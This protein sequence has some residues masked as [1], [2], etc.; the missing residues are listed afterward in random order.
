MA[1]D[2]DRWPYAGEHGD[3]SGFP[4]AHVGLRR[5]VRAQT[6]HSTG[7]WIIGVDSRCPRRGRREARGADVDPDD[8]VVNIA[9][10]GASAYAPEHTFPAYDLG[11]RL[12]ADYIEQDLQ[13]TA[14]GRLVA[15]HD[16]T[17]D[18]TAEGPSQN[19][20]G[21]VRT[22]TLA[23]IK[24]CDV[25]SWFNEE[26]PRR[27][28]P[29]YVGLEV[30]T[31]EQVFR[32]YRHRVNYYIETKSPS[33]YPRMEERLLDLLQ[34]Y[35]LTRSAE[36]RWQVLIQS[37]SEQSLR[38]IHAENAELPLVQLIGSGATSESIRARLDEID[39]YAVGIGTAQSNIDAAL[40]EA[41]HEHCLALH[42]YTVNQPADMDRLIDLGVDGMFTNVP[43]RLNDVLGKDAV[44]GKR[45]AV[46]SARAHA[47][48]EAA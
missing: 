6:R 44:H 4:K 35:H 24:T 9:H 36:R 32:E 1:S 15:L 31:L 22:K 17:L 42:P 2:L 47:A 37:F 20:S 43:D 11:I 21:P 48:C 12:G 23:Q 27:A 45:A 16:T 28:N 7:C 39:D 29:D 18:R 26:F 41:A 10:R 13:V 14:D 38:Q 5:D 8:V 3:G 30:P 19:C 34:E 40:V 46:L 33:L 25:G